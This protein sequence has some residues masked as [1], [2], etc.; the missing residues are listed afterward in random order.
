MRHDVIPNQDAPQS[1]PVC[2]GVLKLD[3]VLFG[4]G[5]AALDKLPQLGLSAHTIPQPREIPFQHGEPG[6]QLLVTEKRPV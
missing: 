5:V 1:S 2:N 6:C 4:L 3:R